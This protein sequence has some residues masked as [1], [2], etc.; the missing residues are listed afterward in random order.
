MFKSAGTNF[1]LGKATIL[2]VLSAPK[3][4]REAKYELQ[5]DVARE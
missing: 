5:V 4:S 1:E 3:P 2:S